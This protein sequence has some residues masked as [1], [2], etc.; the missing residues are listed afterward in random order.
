MTR[1]LAPLLIGIAGCAILLWLGTWQM[2]RLD[3]KEGL[4]ADMEALTSAF[5]AGELDAALARGGAGRWHC[6]GSASESGWNRAIGGQKQRGSP[7]AGVG[8]LPYFR[9]G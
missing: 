5:T 6:L 8:L 9:G 4:L 3:W 1:Y 2:Q 7:G